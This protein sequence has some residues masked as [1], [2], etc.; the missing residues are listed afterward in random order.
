VVVA[1]PPIAVGF[2]G[3]RSSIAELAVGRLFVAEH[4]PCFKYQL[5][6][7]GRQPWQL[8]TY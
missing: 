3:M 5:H 6:F 8:L 4:S 7:L 2:S 1:P